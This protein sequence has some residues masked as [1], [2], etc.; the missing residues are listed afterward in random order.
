MDPEREQEL[1]FDVAAGC[2]VWTTF[3]ALSSVE[4]VPRVNLELPLS[5]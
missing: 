4:R 3:V 1:L 2:D 5:D